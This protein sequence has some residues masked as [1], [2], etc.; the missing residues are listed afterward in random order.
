VG[1]DY[2]KR[3]HTI[4]PSSLL[5]T[6]VCGY[7]SCTIP[8]YKYYSRV[9]GLRSGSGGGDGGGKKEREKNKGATENFNCLFI[10]WS[11]DQIPTAT[12][13]IDCFWPLLHTIPLIKI[14]NK[15]HKN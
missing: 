2:S 14:R 11:H 1:N 7:S 4:I 15:I 3:K 10:F 12:I 9:C 6:L 8:K 13:N 5:K